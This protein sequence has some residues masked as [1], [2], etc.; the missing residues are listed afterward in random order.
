MSKLTITDLWIYPIKSI[1]GIQ[2]E[3]SKVELRGLQYDR[4]WVLA[5]MDGQFVHQRDYPEMALLQPSIEGETMTIKHKQKDI[6]PLSFSMAEPDSEQVSVTVWDDTMPAKPVSDKASQWFSDIIGK[7]VQLL[8]MHEGSIRQADQRYAINESDKVSFA[9]GYPILI[10]SEES[11]SQLNDLANEHVP[12]G[13]FRANVIVKGGEAHIEDRVRK[14]SV[15]ETAWY[16]VKPCARCVMTTIDLETAQKGREPLL[17]LSKYRKVESKI[18]FGENFIPMSECQI[19]VGQE[20]EIEEWK[21][22]A[23]AEDSMSLKERM[24][25]LYLQMKRP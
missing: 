3:S 21:E 16:G 5:D 20:L 19:E 11:L 1:A 9:D 22:P 12:M 7:P 17:T 23:I 15:S 24:H 4:R 2:L 14:L 6:A 10:I 25:E 13:R 8:Y 18:L